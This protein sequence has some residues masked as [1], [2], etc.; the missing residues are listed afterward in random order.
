MN[1][2]PATRHAHACPPRP[3][4]VWCLYAVSGLLCHLNQQSPDYGEVPTL[5]FNPLHFNPGS[6]LYSSLALSFNPEI[7]GS[8]DS[9][10]VVRG[11]RWTLTEH[12]R[13]WDHMPCS[14]HWTIV[15]NSG[16]LPLCHLHQL[17]RY[18]FKRTDWQSTSVLCRYHLLYWEMTK[19]NWEAICWQ[20]FGKLLSSE[21]D[22]LRLLKSWVRMCANI[23]KVT[24][25]NYILYQ[26][27]WCR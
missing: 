27:R 4:L 22:W 26:C 25:F 20:D 8:N 19:W 23:I 12:E 1:E 24:A 21:K 17:R 9:N 3:L 10:A 11:G 5:H 18:T 7:V 2:L 6:I 15:V 16:L 13:T 14:H